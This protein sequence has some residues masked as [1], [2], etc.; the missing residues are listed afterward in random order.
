[1]NDLDTWVGKG[2]AI[3]GRSGSLWG[4]VARIATYKNRRGFSEGSV[5]LEDVIIVE[6]QRKRTV[7]VRVISESLART[8][9]LVDFDGLDGEKVESIV[10]LT[11]MRGDDSEQKTAVEHA[12]SEFGGAVS[13]SQDE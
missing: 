10:F 1:M 9:V 13:E 4:R 6:G 12:L 8:G 5:V 7:P 3:Q 11:L 2:L